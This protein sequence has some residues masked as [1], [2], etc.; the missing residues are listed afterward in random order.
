MRTPVDQGVYMLG[1]SHQGSTSI[2]VR[3]GAGTVSRQLYTPFGAPRGAANQLPG[4][5]GFL[6]Q[7]EDDVFLLSRRRGHASAAFHDVLQNR[8][9]HCQVQEPA[10]LVADSDCW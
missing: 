9:T 6:G 3:N 8:I 5:R 7:V 2:A 10:A 1:G 4:E